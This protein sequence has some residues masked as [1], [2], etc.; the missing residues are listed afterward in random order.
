MN[1]ILQHSLQYDDIFKKI[2]ER[3]DSSRGLKLKGDLWEE[4]C[5][6]YLIAS[7]YEEVY[8][9]REIPVDLRRYLE[10]GKQDNGIDLIAREG[11]H[12]DAVQAKYRK[13][14]GM[15]KR[16][17][18]KSGNVKISG[19][20]G[21]LGRRKTFTIDTGL[22]PLKTLATFSD[23]CNRTGPFRFKIVMTTADGVSQKWKLQEDDIIVAYDTF[24]KSDREVYLNMT[25]STGRVL[26]KQK[27]K[28]IRK[29]N[30]INIPKSKTIE[31][32]RTAKS[33]VKKKEIRMS[34][35][36]PEKLKSKEMERIE[37]IRRKRLAYFDNM[38]GDNQG[39]L[40]AQNNEV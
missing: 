22:I 14:L 16:R 23:L 12:Y 17:I 32:K 27:T 7:G 26:G 37:L 3:I 28:V 35:S 39:S 33:E 11:E 38:F 15:G 18:T 10:L 1:A 34:S 40:L 13:R 24:I 2:L 19:S 31:I 29:S 20:S 21:R 8:L 4:F 25:G 6:L 30:D 36:P 5:K 9:L